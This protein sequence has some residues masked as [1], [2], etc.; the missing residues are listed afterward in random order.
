MAA[1]AQPVWLFDLD[2]TLASSQWRQSLVSGPPGTRDWMRFFE[3]AE[4]DTPVPSVVARLERRV[5]LGFQII[6]LSGRPELVR[7]ST[8]HWLTRH[9][10]S[11]SNLYLRKDQDRRP[12]M[13]VKHDMLK[14]LLQGGLDLVGVTDDTPEFVRTWNE[15]GLKAELVTDPDLPPQPGAPRLH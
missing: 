5:A 3:L 6:I 15:L 1:S 7:V 4:F 2:G 12:N 8:C 10:I 9:G 11:Y 14:E 13:I